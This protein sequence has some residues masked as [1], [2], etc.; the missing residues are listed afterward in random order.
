MPFQNPSVA[1]YVRCST[2]DQS[3]ALQIEELQSHAIERGWKIHEVYDDHGKTGRNTDRPQFQ[4]L[5]EDARKHRFDIVLVWKLD[6]FARS[7]RDLVN[8]LQILTDL[9]IGF[10]SLK[11]S[12]VDLTTPTGRL[13]T[14][15]LSA[16]SEFEVSLT[17]MRVRAGLEAARRKGKRLGRPKKRDDAKILALREQGYSIRQIAKA[18]GVSPTVVQ[19]SLKGVRKS[20]SVGAQKPE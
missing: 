16:F 1:L 9:G 18:I 11:D 14:H 8:T 12:G 3:T 13:L 15:L 20:P 2:A 6:R 4:R 10:V 19:G 17:R 5:M 7:L